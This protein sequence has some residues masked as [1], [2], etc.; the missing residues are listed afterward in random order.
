MISPFL[1]KRNT[2]LKRI[3]TNMRT[4]LI[5]EDAE[6]WIPVMES[7]APELCNAAAV[8]R[9]KKLGLDF[10][11]A[12]NMSWVAKQ[13]PSRH[14]AT[15][16]LR[17]EVLRCLM[18]HF[19][20]IRAYHGCRPREIKS[21]LEEG[22]LPLDTSL[23]FDT[24]SSHFADHRFPEVTPEVLRRALA[25]VDTDLRQGRV[26]F[27]ANKRLL[28]DFCG[29]YLLYGSE[30]F[31]GVLRSISK[32]RDYAQV[33]KDSGIPTLLTCD[34]PIDWLEDDTLLEITGRLIATYFKLH[35]FSNY[36]HPQHGDGLGFEI[37]RKLP[38]KFIASIEHP[39]NIHD[40]IWKHAESY[41]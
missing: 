7:I 30:Y 8:S 14:R 19:T 23:A 22:L 31:V 28:L 20:H 34:V 32:T 40:P 29:H 10:I 17:D 13:L 26:F 9:V 2:L 12:D 27:E 37:F 24:I 4:V 11:P 5:W 36:A 21:Y 38:P 15:F 6:T 3:D 35:V 18:T 1:P 25:N 16:D 41:T 33:L 39:L